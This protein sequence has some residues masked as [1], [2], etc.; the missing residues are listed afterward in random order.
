MIYQ[1]DSHILIYIL[2]FDITSYL[3]NI[4]NIVQILVLH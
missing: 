3:G 4:E 2:L 1:R